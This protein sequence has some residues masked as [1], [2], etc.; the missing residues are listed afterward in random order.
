MK[1]FNW[2][3]I[4]LALMAVASFTFA[5]SQLT[6]LKDALTGLCTGVKGLV[7]IVAFLMLV[8]GGVIYAVGQLLGA[9]TR[10][11][12]S[13][14]ATAMLIGAIICILIVVITP[15][16]LNSLYSQGGG[17]TTTTC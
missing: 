13:V 8:A 9:E 5:A 3:G 10:A 1:K 11:R 16:L 15:P 7:P 14:W 12:A 4:F 6:E 2:L 17:I